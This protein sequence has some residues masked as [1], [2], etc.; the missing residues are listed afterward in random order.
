MKKIFLAGAMGLMAL[1]ASAADSIGNGSFEQNSLG[2][3]SFLYFTQGVTASNWVFTGGT[4]ISRDGSAWGGT[5]SSGDYFAFIQDYPVSGITPAGANSISQTFSLSSAADLSFSFDLAQ[6]AYRVGSGTQTVTVSLDGAVIG[7]Y[8]PFTT[9]GNAWGSFSAAVSGVSAGAHTLT[10]SGKDTN[11][12]DT[13]VFL[14]NVTMSV[15][16]VPEPGSYAM[17]LAGL[18]LMGVIARRRSRA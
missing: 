6:R 3:N 4:G 14:D 13:S 12:G 17:L 11:V 8:T 15:T 5:T 9:L 18:G 2:A 16:A 7:S 10:F 1:S